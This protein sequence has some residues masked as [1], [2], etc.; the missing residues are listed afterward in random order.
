MGGAGASGQ[1]EDPRAD[2]VSGCGLLPPNGPRPSSIW[3]WPPPA[4]GS[5]AVTPLTEGSAR[6]RERCYGLFVLHFAYSPFFP[7]TPKKSYLRVHSRLK[8][9]GA[10]RV[11]T[12][13]IGQNI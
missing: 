2:W 3:P 8:V 7:Q 9:G 10:G 12:A 1:E 6:T 11:G 5:Q 13:K 4:R